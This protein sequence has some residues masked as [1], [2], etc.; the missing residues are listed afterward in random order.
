MATFYKRDP[1]SVILAMVSIEKESDKFEPL[2]KEY[3][4][5][6]PLFQE[7]LEKEALP[8]H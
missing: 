7:K 2:F 8:K 6:K 5:F 1:N 4:R 3:R